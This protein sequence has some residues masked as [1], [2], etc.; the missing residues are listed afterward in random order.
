MMRT[1]T[2]ITRLDNEQGTQERSTIKFGW[3]TSTRCFNK[4]KNLGRFDLNLLFN[5]KQ[6]PRYKEDRTNG[7]GNPF[8]KSMLKA[9]E[10]SDKFE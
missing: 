1:A 7:G 2:R 10:N 8:D 6:E 4:N 3:E 9:T 5:A